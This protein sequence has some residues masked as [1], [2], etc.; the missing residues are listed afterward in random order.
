M[1]H[2]AGLVRA[3]ACETYVADLSSIR[4]YGR[5]FLHGDRVTPY[6]LLM[7]QVRVEVIVYTRFEPVEVN[8]NEEGVSVGGHP[9]K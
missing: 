3:A 2:E 6:N 1:A 5:C 4:L 7:A 9:W 8:I